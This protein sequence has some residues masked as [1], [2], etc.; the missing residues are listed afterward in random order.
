MKVRGCL[1]GVVIGVLL[2]ITLTWLVAGTALFKG[3][4]VGEIDITGTILSSR[5]TLEHLKKFR[6][7]SSIK[8]ILLRVDSP[9]GAVGPSQEI[10]REIRRTVTV[11]P[12]VVS[13]GT[14]A[15]SGAYYLSSAATRIVADPGTITGSIGV[16]IHL[17][18]M[19]GLFG[20]IGYKTVT[21]QSGPLKDIGD[22]GRPMT[23]QEQALL[24]STIDTSYNQFVRDVAGARHLP[25]AEVQKI[26]DGRIILGEDALKLKLIDRIGNYE[27]ALEEAGKLGGIK[28]E[29]QV[30]EAK[31]G[32][33]SLLSL[34]LGSEAGERIHDILADSSSACLMYKLQLK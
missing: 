18:N 10:Y 22:P 8:A 20:K 5:W 16:I 33:S 2:T 32:G 1:I 34:L 26:A 14:V 13:M 30:D 6:K 28:G 19:Q 23:P 4:R 27:D 29:P 21:I 15:A 31:K 3:S 12:V 17:P 11:K 9:G 7:D 25:V 24:Q